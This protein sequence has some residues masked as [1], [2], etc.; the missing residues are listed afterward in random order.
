M[1]EV[2][3]VVGEEEVAVRDGSEGEVCGCGG[4]HPSRLCGM[5]RRGAALVGGRWA[6]EGLCGRASCEG[7][8][9]RE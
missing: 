9:V 6:L 8:R 1:A 5:T 4:K 7:E 2:L 3:V